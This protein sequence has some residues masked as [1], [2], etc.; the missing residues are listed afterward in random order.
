MKMINR[1]YKLRKLSIG[2]VSVGTVFMTTAVAAQESVN[3]NSTDLAQITASNTIDTPNNS[4]N[5]DSAEVS[6]TENNVTSSSL[7]TTEKANENLNEPQPLTSTQSNSNNSVTSNTE[8]SETTSPQGATNDVEKV[9]VTSETIELA[10]YKV[11]N[12]RSDLTVTDGEG[13]DKL[14]KNRDGKNR[15]IFDIHREVIDNQDGTLNVTLSLNPKEIDKGAEVIVLL[16]T[17]QKM[18]QEDFKTAKEN[19]T[20]LVNT[21]TDKSH[22]HNARNSIRLIN[23]YRKVNDPIELTTENVNNTLDQV[24]KNAKEDYDWGVDL[25]GAIHKAREI[26]NKEKQ[27]G[28]RQH[29]VLFSQGEATFSYDIKNKSD[30][31]HVKQNRVNEKITTSNPLFPWLPVFNHTNQNADMIKDLKQFATL[32][33]ELGVNGLSDIDTLLNTAGIGSV[34]LGNVLGGGSLTEYLTLK[35]YDSKVL[36]ENQFDYKKRIGEGYYHHS[37]SE[38]KTKDMP[39]KNSLPGHLDKFFKKDN[40]SAKTWFE[41]ILDAVSLTDYYNQAKKDAL[42]K[43]LEY[44]FYKREYIYYNHNLS[45]QAEAKLA[46]DEG[47]TFY[48]FDVTDPNRVT[49]QRENDNHSEAYA[50]Y[51]NTKAKEAKETSEKR[52]KKFDSYLKSMSENKDF[53]KDVNNPDKF[54][55]ILKNITIKDE[56]TDKVN[57]EKESWQFH[58]L[59]GNSKPK[60][61][62][63][64]K[65]ANPGGW[66]SSSTKES[67]TWTISKD[68]LK[69]AF[70]ENQPLMLTYKLKIVN[71]KFK[72]N[73]RKKRDLSLPNS[74]EARSEKIISNTIS[75]TINDKKVNKQKL[76]D[77]TLTY[78]KEKLVK[79]IVNETKHE[80]LKFKTQEFLDNTLP[81][82]QKVLVTKGENG[83][84]TS[85]FQNTYLGDKLIDSK[86]LLK[87]TKNPRHE[88]IKVGT[89]V[90]TPA[91]ED[92]NNQ[93]VPIVITDHTQPD[94]IEQPSYTTTTEDLPTER[95]DLIV[96]SQSDLLD[97][98]ED[99]R[100]GMSGSNEETVIEEDTHPNLI[101]HFDN[102]DPNSEAELPQ[103][104]TGEKDN[105][106]DSQISMLEENEKVNHI[107]QITDKTTDQ[108]P[109]IATATSDNQ[110]PQTGGKENS[111][112]AFFTMTAL[113]I[114]GAAGILNKKHH[115]KY[116]D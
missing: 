2:L 110:L 115:D 40:E 36:N 47:I 53:L 83:S 84:I 22:P 29:I 25:Q 102:E 100:V 87:I 96:G 107:L 86:L 95:D 103:D 1:K 26:F 97:S 75:Y 64:H 41:S 61:T 55:D 18:T 34:L 3:S 66:F 31:K 6:K 4:L 76:D 60:N 68:E 54:K 9:D 51:L 70:E 11:D 45:A 91:S 72:G 30:D 59:T 13:T 113:A 98:I 28:K 24:W 63:E 7:E 43:V 58:S 78:S 101:L 16:D 74:K 27:S 77:V 62:V 105:N 49:N 94:T 104:S 111:C 39:Y 80:T 37:F 85:E 32:A 14:I 50:K 48:S 88:V 82:G 92:L 99:T 79:K 109:P 15:D 93:S 81:Q 112:E 33:K 114:I 19:I 52:N 10:T 38:R 21:L 8:S 108:V 42:L 89:K 71:E 67:L 20:K 44:L 46:R 17:S 90:E 56:F 5:N 35:E 12:E 116:L 73:I 65:S 57:V 106:E 23:F 69:K